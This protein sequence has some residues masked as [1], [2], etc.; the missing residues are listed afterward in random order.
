M[1]GSSLLVPE[2]KLYPWD[3]VVRC[4]SKLARTPGYI[5]R[6]SRHGAADQKKL[7]N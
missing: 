6:G 4:A 7:T 3:T 1:A 5:H 2:R